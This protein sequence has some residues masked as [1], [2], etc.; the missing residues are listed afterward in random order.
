MKCLACNI[1]LTDREATRKYASSGTFIDLCNNCFAHI[2]DDIPDIESETI[3][4]EFSQEDM[5]SAIRDYEQ[6]AFA[7]DWK[8]NG[9]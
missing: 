8:S 9:S 7:P 5:D 6:Q 2:A 1:T 4:D 3:A